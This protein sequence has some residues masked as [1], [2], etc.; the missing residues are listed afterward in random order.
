MSSKFQRKACVFNQIEIEENV[1]RPFHQPTL[2]TGHSRRNRKYL[3]RWNNSRRHW[4]FGGKSGVYDRGALEKSAE[5]IATSTDVPKIAMM[6]P[7]TGHTHLRDYEDSVEIDI[8]DHDEFDSRPSVS[9]WSR[10][11][12]TKLAQDCKISVRA[13]VVP[14]PGVGSLSQLFEHTFIDL[15]VVKK[16]R[17][18]VRIS[19]LFITVLTVPDT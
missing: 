17:F 6:A 9:K 12:R 7:E 19:I 4:N 14:F 13:A 8:F 2:I 16:L 3:Y 10:Q 15:T 1:S 18:A 5:V 11:R